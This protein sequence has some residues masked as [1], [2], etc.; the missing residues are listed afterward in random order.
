MGKGVLED[1]EIER[2]LAAAQRL[3]EMSAD[4]FVQLNFTARDGLLASVPEPEGLI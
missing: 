2:F 4:D 3:P 1:V